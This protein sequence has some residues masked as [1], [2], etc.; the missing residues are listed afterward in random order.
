MVE[1]RKAFDKALDWNEADYQGNTLR[2][3]N[4]AAMRAALAAALN[5]ESK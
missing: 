2:E 5:K 3:R 4:L 1:A